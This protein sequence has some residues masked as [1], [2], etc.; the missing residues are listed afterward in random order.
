MSS[1]CRGD[2]EGFDDMWN[3]LYSRFFSLLDN[4]Y[5]ESV[6]NFRDS[7]RKLYVVYLIKQGKKSE[8][9]VNTPPHC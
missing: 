5:V 3:F 1:L 2:Y 7:L 4:S 8:V 6:G 9:D